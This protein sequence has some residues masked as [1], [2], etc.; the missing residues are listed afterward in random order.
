MEITSGLSQVILPEPFNVAPKV[1]KR[2]QKFVKLTEKHG[3]MHWTGTVHVYNLFYLYLMNKYKSRCLLLSSTTHPSHYNNGLT[4]YLPNHPDYDIM[5][6]EIHYLHTSIQLI[7]C[8][9]QHRHT[10][11]TA[12]III[13]VTMRCSAECSHANVLIY[14][15]MLNEIEHFE[16]HGSRFTHLTNK[17]NEVDVELAVFIHRLNTHLVEEGFPAVRFIPAH[18]VCPRIFEGFQL[19]S[20]VEHI[21]VLNGIENNEFGEIETGGYC[22]AWCMFFT[23]LVLKNPTISSAQLT[24]AALHMGSRNRM[25]FARY[26]KNVIRGY[27]NFISNKIEKY[28][29]VLFGQK[30]TVSLLR[31]IMRTPSHALNDKINEF[32]DV[33]LTLEH[34]ALNDPH[35]D[36]NEHLL[37]LEAMLSDPTISAAD[38]HHALSLQHIILN[39]TILKKIPTASSTSTYKSSS[40]VKNPRFTLADNFFD[41][42]S[43]SSSSSSSPSSSKTK[44]N[45]KKRKYSSPPPIRKSARLQSMKTRSKRA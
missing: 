23:E 19:E 32:M 16:P 11:I 25:D 37:S 12:P 44:T 7:D 45:T 6:R 9:K 41:Y 38:R 2:L 36:I 31:D 14:R 40:F 1:E 24:K 3:I 10:E 15:P 30:I 13:P 29:T 20:S 17:K 35:Y 28:F 26:L 27:V 21:F 4:I 5:E 33:L 22:L 8:L 42:T 34:R 43:S 18:I 39:M